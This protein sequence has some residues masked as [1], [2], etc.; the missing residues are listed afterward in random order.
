MGLV[1]GLLPVGQ[2]LPPAMP[3]ERE[4]SVNPR[5]SCCWLEGNE[6]LRYPIE[7]LK[8]HIYPNSLTP[9]VKVFPGRSSPKS[10]MLSPDS[11]SSSMGSFPT[12]QGISVKGA[13]KYEI[14]VF[15]KTLRNSFRIVGK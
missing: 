7:S 6:V 14:V 11:S 2:L 15:Y 9:Y 13:K 10:S 8:G 4:N 5:V 3:R 12:L 1:L